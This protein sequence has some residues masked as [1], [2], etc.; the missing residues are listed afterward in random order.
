[1]DKG[2]GGTVGGYLYTIAQII[3]CVT[4]L[5][6]PQAAPI[7]NR[8]LAQRDDH[9]PAFPGTYDDQP[10]WWLDA[11]RVIKSEL[12]ALAKCQCKI[13]SPKNG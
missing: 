4:R 3:A 10:A 1:M 8:Y 2:I 7:L 12:A 13:C 6:D 5:Y 9:I 11:S